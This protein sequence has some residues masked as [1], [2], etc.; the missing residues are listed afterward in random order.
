LDD[1]MPMP[2]RL[3]RF[4][5][6]VEPDLKAT[7]V[8][9]RPIS[10]G[11]SRVTAMAEI[12]AA[13]G[14]EQKLIVRSDP[15]SG[16]GVFMSDRDREWELLQAL[17]EAGTIEIPRPRWYDGTGELM[18]SKTII[19]DHVT[20]TPLQLTLGPDADVGAART[21][22]LEVAA[23]LQRTPIDSM[24][25]VMEHPTDWDSYLDGAIDIYSRAEREL[26]DSSPIVRYVSAWL[27]ANRP[28]PVPLGVVHG[29]FQPG[30]VLIA[31]DHPPVVIDWEFT[32][33]GDPREDV[34]YYSGS[35]LPNSLYTA[36]R[37]AFLAQYRK[38]MGFSEE[39]VNPQVMDYFFILGMAELF[40]Q[41]M[42]GADALSLGRGK[43]IMHT[44]LVNSICYFHQKYL[45]ISTP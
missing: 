27:R 4:L 6:E 2:E 33:I 21:I 3:E 26:A 31:D 43:G 45:E 11:Y 5:A 24:P 30:N 28:P 42:Q 14:S 12:R 1:T 25:A 37:D 22:F 9:Y 19:M 16:Q 13:D 18:G 44:F 39:Q 23:A 35:P 8:A 20:G 7:V 40:V 29:D 17:W 15:P 38:L 34:G 36:D 32:R 10:G 41:M